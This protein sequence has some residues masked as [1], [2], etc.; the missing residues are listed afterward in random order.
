MLAYAYDSNG[1]Y[2]GT[3]ERQPSPLEPGVFLMPAMATQIAP[4][5][6][7]A[8]TEPKWNGASWDL[9]ESRAETLRKAAELEAQKTAEELLLQEQKEA[10]EKALLDA[11][12][13]VVAPIKDKVKNKTKLSDAEIADLFDYIFYL[14]ER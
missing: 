2:L 8:T 10:E 7:T 9:V 13:A 3:I 4:P 14:L 6:A 12:K 5:A 1:Y 11:K